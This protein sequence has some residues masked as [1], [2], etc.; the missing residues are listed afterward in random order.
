MKPY[1]KYFLSLIAA[2]LAGISW[3]AASAGSKPREL[4]AK[5]IALYKPVRK[6]PACNFLTPPVRLKVTRTYDIFGGDEFDTR[7]CGYLFTRREKIFDDPVTIAYFR[8][9]DAADR[10]FLTAIQRGISSGNSVN[11]VRDRAY[12][13]NLGCLQKGKIQGIKHDRR[14]PYLTDRVERSILKSTPQK[15]V[16]LILSFGK[17]IG[18]EC[19][20]CNLAHRIRLD[21]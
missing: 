20:C 21:E 3:Q 8:I 9:M 15:P 7:V 18:S 5:E 12:Y 11:F 14:Y 19:E 10:N 2:I 13:F 4:A 17:H 6:P 1:C 16:R